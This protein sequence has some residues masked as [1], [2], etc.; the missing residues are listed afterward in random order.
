MQIRPKAKTLSSHD[1]LKSYNIL[2]A[3]PN[4]NIIP[5]SSLAY[6]VELPMIPMLVPAFLPCI[7]NL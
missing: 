4:A 6:D 5:G 1:V 3:N 2:N 7:A